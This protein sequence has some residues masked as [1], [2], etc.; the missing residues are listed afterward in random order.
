MWLFTIFPEKVLASY[1][2]AVIA[3]IPVHVSDILGYQGPKTVWW[4]ESHY[5][6]QQNGLLSLWEM[7]FPGTRGSSSLHMGYLY[8]ASQSGAFCTS[9]V[10]L[11][12]GEV[13]KLHLSIWRQEVWKSLPVCQA[14]GSKIPN[15]HSVPL[16]YFSTV[17]QTS[18]RPIKC[19]QQ[20]QKTDSDI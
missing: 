16:F 13:T 19:K 5:G 4:H 2:F 3:A 14:S 12:K 17:L 15:T 9:G 1:A 10:V 6:A 20:Q 11:A 7:H 8:L 18:K